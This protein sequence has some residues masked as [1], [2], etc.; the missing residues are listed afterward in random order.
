MALQNK[1]P[2]L[3]KRKSQGE[4]KIGR[5]SQMGAWRQDGLADWLWVIMWLWLRPHN[6]ATLFL[7]DKYGDLAFQVEWVSNETVKY[8]FEF[9]GT[10][11]QEWLLWQGAKAIARVNYRPILSSERVPQIKKSAIV[12][13]KTKFWS[14]T[15][16]QTGRPTVGRKLTSTSASCS[17][18]GF[19]SEI[20][21][22]QCSTEA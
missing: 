7:E 14:P 11:I 16:R 3:S 18:V 5:G 10:S 19:V 8:G 2:Q 22:Y 13:Q 12:R 21:A 15:P 9:C 20:Q 1:K 4:R 17:A 6:W